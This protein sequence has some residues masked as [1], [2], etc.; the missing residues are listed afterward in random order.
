MGIFASD[1]EAAAALGEV[2]EGLR[3]EGEGD[4]E[5]DDEDAEDEDGEGKGGGDAGEDGE[6]DGGDEEQG[7]DAG[8][9]RIEERHLREIEYMWI[10]FL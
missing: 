4:V 6:G 7:H 2:G 8:V 9:E 3:Y 1:D 5:V 10:F